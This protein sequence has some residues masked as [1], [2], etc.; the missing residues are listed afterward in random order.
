MT[1]EFL[2]GMTKSFLRRAAAG[3][4]LRQQTMIQREQG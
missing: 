1:G 3:S 2:M 4:F